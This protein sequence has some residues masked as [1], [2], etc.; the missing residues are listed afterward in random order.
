MTTA[1]LKCRHCK[2]RKPR[3]SMLKVPLGSF[4][5]SQCASLYGIA[6]SGKQQLKKKRSEAWKAKRDRLSNDL[7]H[8]ISITQDAFNRMIRELDKHLPCVSCSKPAG[9]YALTAGHYLTVGAHPELRFDARNC[10]GQ[11]SGC[12]SGVQRFAKGDKSSTK[13]KF[14]A[15][16]ARRYGQELVNYVTGPHEA[17]H[18]TCD[19][20]KALRKVFNAERRRLERGEQPSRNWREVEHGQL[21]QAS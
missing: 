15:E 10:H 19:D 2:E 4:C 20:L 9:T 5:D 18:Y 3:D 7:S 12:N 16:I 6:K 14:T 1:T 21:H 17:K 8:Q 11:C 13:A